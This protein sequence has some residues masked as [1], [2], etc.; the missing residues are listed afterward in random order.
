MS[1]LFAKLTGRARDRVDGADLR[2][3]TDTNNH[4][5]VVV[6]VLSDPPLQGM[7]VQMNYAEAQQSG[8][9]PKSGSEKKDGRSAKDGTPQ[10]LKCRRSRMR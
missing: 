3:R 6:V 4:S 7:G 10:R 1:K 5:R 8:K 2:G 9:T